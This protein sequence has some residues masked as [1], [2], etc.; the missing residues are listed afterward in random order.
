M[1]IGV[2]NFQQMLPL[3][4]FPFICTSLNTDCYPIVNIGSGHPLLLRSLALRL[5]AYSMTPFYTMEIT[6]PSNGGEFRQM[7]PSIYHIC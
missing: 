4:T 1:Y 3:P 2:L 5:E 6:A 7:L